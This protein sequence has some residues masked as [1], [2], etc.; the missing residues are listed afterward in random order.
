MLFVLIGRD[1]PNSRETRPAVRPRHLEY[2]KPLDEAGRIV[3]A[4]PMT[5]F[6][7]SLFILEAENIEAV[8]VLATNDPY[9]KEGI[10]ESFEIHPFK[11][12]LPTAQYAS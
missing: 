12:V 8:R 4:G 9:I 10:F 2:W 5:D 3:V 1:A 7:G 6:A 11:A